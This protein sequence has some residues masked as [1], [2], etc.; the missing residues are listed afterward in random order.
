MKLVLLLVCALGLRAHGQDDTGSVRNLSAEE[1]GRALAVLRESHVDA[2]S[3][4][5]QRM[6][7]ATLQG[8]VD[9]LT[10]G[11]VVTKEEKTKDEPSPFRSEI[12]DG[13]IGYLRA[14]S[15]QT[16]NLAQLDA[17]LREFSGKKVTGVVLDLRATP[18]SPNF[19]VAAQM[20]QRFVPAG[21][22]LFSL[23]GPKGQTTKDFQS[24]GPRLSD[25]VLVVVVD[26]NTSGAAEA[27]AASLRSAARAL[28]VGVP[29]SG[30][31]AEFVTVPLGGGNFLR[32]A[33][34]AVRL[35]DGTAVY[36]G[37]LAPD[38]DVPQS[39]SD[40]EAVLAAAMTAGVGPLVFEK[41][42]ARLN[43]AALVAGTDPELAET[44]ETA[45]PLYDRPLQRAVDLVVAVRLFHGRD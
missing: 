6:S 14:G 1:V 17:A 44:P 8:L 43:E 5:E 21:S 37:G 2:A 28:L 3:L 33:A 25:T 35:P 27:L 22:P 10:P 29:T 20:A 9:L 32:Y 40:R 4:D 13:D 15:V 11:V 18:D 24:A 16:E 39:S 19:E 45:P 26:E 12:L 41:E 23:A 38:I 42:R 36:P 31:C 30:R 34:A 7:R